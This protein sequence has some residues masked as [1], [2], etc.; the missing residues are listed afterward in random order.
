MMYAALRLCPML[1]GSPGRVDA[2]ARRWPC[3]ACER[4]VLLPAYAGSTAGFAVVGNSYWQ[5][6]QAAQAVEV[7][8]QPRPGG[9][10]DSR[11][12]D[13]AAGSALSGPAR[14]SP[15]FEQGRR[16]SAD[17][18]GAGRDRGAG[19]ARRTWRTPR[20]SR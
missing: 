5:A 12:I 13:S 2:P 1:G 11:R 15:F 9:A 6:Q 8:W 10:L 16:R 17:E 7:E 20:W 3:P 4:L 14:A 19:T 18:A